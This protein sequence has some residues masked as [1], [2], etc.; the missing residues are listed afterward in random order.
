[1]NYSRHQKYFP[2]RLEKP[3]YLRLPCPFLGRWRDCIGSYR[4]KRACTHCLV[5]YGMADRRIWPRFL[6]V[7]PCTILGILQSRLLDEWQRYGSWISKI[8]GPF[9]EN[10]KTTKTT[11]KPHALCTNLAVKRINFL[12]LCF[13]HYNIWRIVASST[14][15]PDIDI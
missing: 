9:E 8:M 2:C 14:G 12:I 10:L 1:M 3:D 11:G 13:M 4:L 6:H 15:T 7:S 5:H